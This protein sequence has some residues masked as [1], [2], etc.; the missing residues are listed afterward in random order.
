MPEGPLRMPTAWVRPEFQAHDGLVDLDSL[1]IMDGLVLAFGF[2]DDRGANSYGSGIMVAP[3]LLVT[4]THVAEETKGTAGMAFSFLSS[5][6][7]RLWSPHQVHILTGPRNDV[8]MNGD[9]RRRVSDVTLCSCYPMSDVALDQPLLMA[10]LEVAIP[11]I[12]E[13]LWAVGYRETAREDAPSMAMLCSSGLVTAV[14]LEG[15]GTL[16]PGP[17]IEIG[18]NTVGGMSGG[19]VFNTLGHVIGIVSTSIEADDLLGPTYVSLIWPALV[20][21]VDAPWPKEYW[22]NGEASLKLAN[23]LGFARIHGEVEMDG[24]GGFKGR[25]PNPSSK[26]E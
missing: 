24:N 19:P 11:K 25:L 20:G 2:I 22:P 3:G 8:L 12:G 17:C 4:A 9:D 18:M 13:R 26:V 14:Y 7:M 10:H 23:S 16:L 6:K 21:E 1:H 5:G 15:R